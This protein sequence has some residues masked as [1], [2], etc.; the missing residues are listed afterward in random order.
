[1]SGY[2]HF[3]NRSSDLVEAGHESTGFVQLLQAGAI[4]AATTA[5]AEL[6]SLR[7]TAAFRTSL[8]A[9]TT[10]SVVKVDTDIYRDSRTIRLVLSCRDASF[11]TR[12]LPNT[13]LYG[14]VSVGSTS[15][16]AVGCQPHAT[17]GACVVTL[18][19]PA[20]WINGEMVHVSHGFS[21]T[22]PWT[23]Q[24]NAITPH[25]YSQLSFEDHFLLTVP[26]APV[27]PGASFDM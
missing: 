14:K 6:G 1:M 2:G 12:V 9:A 3:K 27:L 16:S 7:T 24:E 5:V 4:G 20:T 19:A 11:N 22:G 10:L 8:E 17:T 25:A 15:T 26:A 13:R 18:T 23:I 21:S